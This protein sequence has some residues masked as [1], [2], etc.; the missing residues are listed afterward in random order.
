M[1]VDKWNS[2][3]NVVSPTYIIMLVGNTKP[4]STTLTGTEESGLISDEVFLENL[5]P[6]PPSCDCNITD[7]NLS[8]SGF[9]AS[10]PYHFYT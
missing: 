4:E 5:H 1:D 6:E 10:I 7:S 3:K 2:Y 9:L 8:I